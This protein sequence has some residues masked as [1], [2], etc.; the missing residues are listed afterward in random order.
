MPSEPS[1]LIVAT[2]AGSLVSVP[3]S[4]VWPIRNAS[5]QAVSNWSEAT[6]SVT[7]SR[8]IDRSPSVAVAWRVCSAVVARGPVPSAISPSTSSWVSRPRSTLASTAAMASSTTYA[9]TSG[10]S[11]SGA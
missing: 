7:P 3:I 4:W 9:C 5:A 2:A 10:L 1:S 11:D 8:I 6:N